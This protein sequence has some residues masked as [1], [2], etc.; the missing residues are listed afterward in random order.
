MTIS[1]PESS[2]LTTLSGIQLGRGRF[3]S[4]SNVGHN[5]MK[6]WNI[7]SLF[8]HALTPKQELAGYK[9][10][11]FINKNHILYQCFFTMK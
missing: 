7:S 1:F 9:C 3:S 5:E 11:C 8:P 4:R 2:K 10:G 6:L